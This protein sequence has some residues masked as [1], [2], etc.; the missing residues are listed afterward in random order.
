MQRRSDF[1][2]YE[3]LHS[4]IFEYKEKYFIIQEAQQGR[5][6]NPAH[7]TS[8][9]GTDYAALAAVFNAKNVDPDDLGSAILIALDKFDTEPHPFEQ[10]D[11]PARNRCIKKWIGYRGIKEFE[12]NQRGV[13]VT[14]RIVEKKYIVRPFANHTIRPWIG[15]QGM[16][17]IVL[18][19]GV[20]AKEIGDAVL[21]AFE[22]ATY[23]PNRTDPR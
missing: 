19:D 22:I 4:T 14:Y 17:E 15:P 20:S 1:T 8:Q 9:N 18:E 10:V 5:V 23:N 3:Y 13:S 2:I 16:P 21:R 6:L 12:V 11:I 7:G